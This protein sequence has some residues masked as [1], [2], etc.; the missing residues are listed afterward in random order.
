MD[1][2]GYGAFLG[3][4]AILIYHLRCGYKELSGISL[5]LLEWF[6]A[7]SNKWQPGL[8]CFCNGDRRIS[9]RRLQATMFGLM[10]QLDMHLKDVGIDGTSI[11]AAHCNNLKSLPPMRTN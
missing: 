6:Y 3:I 9:S 8:F 1:A 7:L 5:M 10:R 2:L 11:Y 4:Y